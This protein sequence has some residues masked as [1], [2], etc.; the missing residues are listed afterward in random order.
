MSEAPGQHAIGSVREKVP[1]WCE[2]TCRSRSWQLVV[3]ESLERDPGQI[4]CSVFEGGSRCMLLE[5]ADDAQSQDCLGCSSQRTTIMFESDPVEQDPGWTSRY[6]DEST[7]RSCPA[8][9]ASATP[10]SIY[11]VFHTDGRKFGSKLNSDK[12]IS[13]VPNTRFRNSVD[14]KMRCK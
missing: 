13:A 4:A 12:R 2:L 6:E 9:M 14:G 10:A 7:K 11:H 8:C 3:Y 1:C 5:E